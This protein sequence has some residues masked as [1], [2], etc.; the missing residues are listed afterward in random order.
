[1]L[2]VRHARANLS[3]RRMHAVVMSRTRLVCNVVNPR[4]HEVSALSW[5]KWRV[6][7]EQFQLFRCP[8]RCS[9]AFRSM[10]LLWTA[11]GQPRLRVQVAH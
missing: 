5:R 10:T 4:G 7:Y 9:S 3:A 2:V 1:M 11:P 8:Y 6:A